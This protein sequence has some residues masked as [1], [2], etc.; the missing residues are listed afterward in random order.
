MPMKGLP[1][2][3]RAAAMYVALIEAWH[4][5]TCPEGPDCSSRALHLLS[6]TGQERAA[7]L[8]KH[9]AVQRVLTADPET[10]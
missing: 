8:T 6:G 4:D 2:G 5:T 10:G 9:D 3:D 1:G 7:A